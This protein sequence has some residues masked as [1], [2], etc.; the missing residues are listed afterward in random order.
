M[1][2]TKNIFLIV[3]LMLLN[4]SCSKKMNPEQSKTKIEF[5]EERRLNH[6]LNI[7]QATIINSLQELTEL[8]GKL[9]DPSFPR[10][11]PIPSFDENTEAILII[12]PKLK[13][14]TYGD[15]EIESIEKSKSKLWINYREIENWEFSENKWD[16]P[17][18]ILRVSEKPS[19][20]Q[21]NRI[22]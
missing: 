15:I 8:Y 4:L 9:Q 21:L 14:L 10:S 19:E 3:G 7:K 20:I 16:N 17:I 6:G 12:K 5:T 18:V 13:N 1:K 2:F 11:A 22:N